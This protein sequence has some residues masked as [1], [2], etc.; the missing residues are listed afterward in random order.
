LRRSRLLG[1]QTHEAQ[2]LSDTTIRTLVRTHGQLIRQAEQAEL[3]ALLQQP[4]LATL[5]LQLVLHDQPQ[6]RASWPKE[7]NLAVELALAAEQ[8]HPPEGVRWADWERGKRGTLRRG[9]ASGRGSAASG[10][11]TGA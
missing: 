4:D 3:A 2:M 10:A 7:L 11:G 9:H 6:R 5:D 1:W 8:P